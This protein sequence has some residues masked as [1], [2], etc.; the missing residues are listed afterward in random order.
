MPYILLSL[1]WATTLFLKIKLWR[2]CH[3]PLIPTGNLPRDFTWWS[4]SM[5]ESGGWDSKSDTYYLLTHLGWLLSKNRKYVLDK[6]V[7]RCQWECKTVQ[8][9]W[10]TFWLSL[11]KLKMEL[12]SDPALPLLGIYPKEL[13]TEQQRDICTTMFITALFRITEMWKQSK[14]PSTD[15]WISRIW[16]SLK[17]KFWHMLQHGWVLRTLCWAK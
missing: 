10:K 16:S 15:E 2:I 14:C 3:I 6:D 11:I 7:E 1:T 17:R 9:L 12:A 13:K 4:L 8:L 5:W